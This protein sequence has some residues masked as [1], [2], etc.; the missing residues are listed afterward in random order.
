MKAGTSQR[1]EVESSM[2]TSALRRDISEKAS[3][4]SSKSESS[5]WALRLIYY[6]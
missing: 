2:V 3:L 5:D 1:E 6:E 4:R